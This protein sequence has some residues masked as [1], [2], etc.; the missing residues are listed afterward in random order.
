MH[1]FLQKHNAFSM[2]FCRSAQT[3]Y[4]N[5]NIY[6]V[7]LHITTQ[8]IHITKGILEFMLIGWLAGWLAG[9][10]ARWL[11]GLLAGWLAGC[12][13]GFLAGLLVGWLA[14]WPVWNSTGSDWNST[15]CT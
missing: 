12:L 14:C 2:F 3:W 11:A 8:N 10:F 5:V 4:N 1:E 9:L 6:L 7:K 15:G 13:V